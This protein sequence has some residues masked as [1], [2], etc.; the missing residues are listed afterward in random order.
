MDC[1]YIRKLLNLLAMCVTLAY[2]TRTKFL[3]PS[4]SLL[5]HKNL[6]RFL[7]PT[8][9]AVKALEIHL[10][11]TTLTIKFFLRSHGRLQ[12]KYMT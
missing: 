10:F 12:V 6:L 7:E 1:K 8:L 9:L 3:F 4:P 11:L 5:G 2:L